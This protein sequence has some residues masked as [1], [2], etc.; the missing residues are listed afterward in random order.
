[1]TYLI[2]G[3]V[4]LLWGNGISNR[5]LAMTRENEHESRMWR[6][7]QRSLSFATVINMVGGVLLAIGVIS[8]L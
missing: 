2:I 8:L 3:A 1:M 6:I 5:S 7:G 4:L